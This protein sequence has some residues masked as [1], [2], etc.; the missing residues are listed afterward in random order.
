M[1]ET[2]YT[3]N[4]DVINVDLLVT[5][6]AAAA[7]AE[8][9]SRVDILHESPKVVDVW[10]PN[11]LSAGDQATLDSV[12]VAQALEETKAAKKLAINDYRDYKLFVVKYTWP[13]DGNSYDLDSVSQFKIVA[14]WSRA[15]STDGLPSGFTWRD[16]NNVDRSFTTQQFKD[17]CGDLWVRGNDVHIASKTHKNN[18]DALTTAAD[19]NSYDYTTNPSWPA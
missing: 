8:T 3:Y 7:L 14:T 11:A 5:Q 15:N 4:Q 9:L 10:F 12:L 1:S 16:A 2:K 13:T 18:V 19:A 17:F 6:I